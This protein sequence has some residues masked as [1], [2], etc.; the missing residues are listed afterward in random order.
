MA[1]LE[2]YCFFVSNKI[3]DEEI[4][5]LKSTVV[6]VAPSL[7]KKEPIV[8]LKIEQSLLLHKE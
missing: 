1:Y 6:E 8:Y 4:E 5:H 7:K 3:P 2:K